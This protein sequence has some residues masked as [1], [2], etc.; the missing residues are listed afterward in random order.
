MQQEFQVRSHAWIT[1]LCVLT[2]PRMKR[3]PRKVR[4]TKAFRKAAGKEMTIVSTLPVFH[5]HLPPSLRRAGLDNRVREEEKRSSPLQPRAG[6][7]DGEGDEEDSRD[8]AEAGACILEEQVRLY[9]IARAS[10]YVC[11]YF[12]GWLLRGKNSKHTE[13]ATSRR[14]RSSLSSP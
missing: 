1:S 4:W 10:D 8:Q 11:Q 2:W 7:D 9:N 13:S 6:A 14:P 12:A 5:P 3:N